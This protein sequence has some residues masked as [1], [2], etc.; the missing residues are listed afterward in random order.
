[1]HHER[2]RKEPMPGYRQ[3]ALNRPQAILA[4]LEIQK[5][6]RNH[7]MA[8]NGKFWPI[9]N[10]AASPSSWSRPLCPPH[11]IF[12][13]GALEKLTDR[14]LLSINRNE[15]YSE[16]SPNHEPVNSAAPLP[17]RSFWLALFGEPSDTRTGKAAL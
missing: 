8:R 16:L 9:T 3:G 1:M 11:Y 14:C 12:A 5:N 13:H 7:R 4:R 6:G 10:S 2:R 17:T 15:S